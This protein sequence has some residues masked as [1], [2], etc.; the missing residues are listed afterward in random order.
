MFAAMVQEFA[1]DAKNNF[2]FQRFLKIK[3]KNLQLEKTES[4]YNSNIENVKQN[5][6]CRREK[7]L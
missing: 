5:L 6:E 1:V 3:V 4:H 7:L 2:Y